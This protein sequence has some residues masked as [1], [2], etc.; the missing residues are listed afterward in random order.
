MPYSVSIDEFAAMLRQQYP[1]MGDGLS[2]L[3][4]SQLYFQKYPDSKYLE[5]IENP[6]LLFA[7]AEDP[8]A[9]ATSDEPMG[10]KAANYAIARQNYATEG[11]KA[12]PGFGK[13]LA[14]RMAEHITSI[15][16]AVAGYGGYIASA[17]GAEETGQEMID[18]GE[19]GAFGREWGRDFMEEWVEDDLELQALQLWQEDEPVTFYEDGKIGNFVQ[20]DMFVRGMASAMPS[21]IEMGLT[22]AATRGA[23]ALFYVGKAGKASL[24]L[25]RAWKKAHKA[26]TIGGIAAGTTLEGSETWNTAMAYGKEQG[27][28][29]KEAAKIAGVAT[30]IAAPIKGAME[31]LGF[32]KMARAIGLKEVGEREM[33]RILTGKVIKNMVG[34]GTAKGL[35]VGSTEAMTEW[36]QFMTDAIVQKGYKDGLGETPAEILNALIQVG[37]DEGWSAEARESIYGGFLMGGTTGGTGGATKAFGR[38]TPEKLTKRLKEIDAWYE[39]VEEKLGVEN[40]P[41]AV[42]ELAKIKKLQLFDEVM[43]KAAEGMTDEQAKEFFKEVD[44]HY[45]GEDFEGDVESKPIVTKYKDIDEEDYSDYL[46]S[47]ALPD[48]REKMQKRLSEWNLDAATDEQ[49]E[50]DVYKYTKA[51]V[52]AKDLPVKYAILKFLAEDP[53]AFKVMQNQPENI[54]KRLVAIA[55]KGIIDSGGLGVDFDF[56]KATPQQLENLVKMFI[57]KGSFEMSSEGVSL[58]ESTAVTTNWDLE[59]MNDTEIKSLFVHQDRD[60]AYGAIEDIFG[61]E[62]ADKLIDDITDIAPD[63]LTTIETEAEVSNEAIEAAILGKGVQVDEEQAKRILAHDKAEHPE[64]FEEEETPAPVVEEKDTLKEYRDEIGKPEQTEE[65]S[66][67]Y[68]LDIYKEEMASGENTE[69]EVIEFG[70]KAYK[71]HKAEL[72]KFDKDPVAYLENELYG[73]EGWVKYVEEQK[74]KDPSFDAGTNIDTLEKLL[75][76]AKEQEGVDTKPT[77]V[78]GKTGKER[79]KGDV[80]A[81]KYNKKRNEIT[82]DKDALK[83]KFD[84]KA[85]TKP[86]VKGVIALPENAFETYEAFEQFVVEHEVLHSKWKQGDGE[87]AGSYENRINKMAMKNLGLWEEGV[88]ETSQKEEDV[89][90]PES[91][92]LSQAINYTLGERGK[93]SKEETSY[94]NFVEEAGKERDRLVKKYKEEWDTIVK[95]KND[96][97][98]ADARIVEKYYDELSDDAK[99]YFDKLAP[100]VEQEYEMEGSPYYFGRHPDDGLI[101]GSN[102]YGLDLDLE[103][104]PRVVEP[105]TTLQERMTEQIEKEINPSAKKHLKK[106]QVK[107]KIATQFIGKGAEGSSTYNY[108]RM[109]QKEGVANTTKYTKDDIIYVSSNGKR[110]GRVNPVKDGVLQGVYKNID[111]A[112][113]VGAKIVMDTAAHLEATSGYNIGE[114]ALANYMRDNGYQRV[115]ETGV[116]EK[117]WEGTIIRPPSTPEADNNITSDSQDPLLAALTNRTALARKK[118]NLDKQYPV[119]FS[120]TGK[121]YRESKRFRSAE[122]A[123]Q[124]YRSDRKNPDIA[125]D[126]ALMVDIIQAKLEQ[127]PELAEQITER[128]GTD[129]LQTMRHDIGQSRWTGKGEDSLFIRALMDAYERVIAPPSVAPTTQ[130]SPLG[131][132]HIPKSK[133]ND[134]TTYEKVV[135][136]IIRETEGATTRKGHKAVWFGEKPYSYTGA[137]HTA[138][139]MPDEIIEIMHKVEDALGF[140]RGYYNSVL[141]NEYPAGVGIDAHAD[142]EEILVLDETGHVGHVGVLSLGGDSVIRIHEVGK[143]TYPVGMSGL[144]EELTIK[145]GDIYNLPAGDFQNAYLHSVGKSKAPRIS[146]TFRKI[147]EPAAPASEDASGTGTGSILDIMEEIEQEERDKEN[148]T[149][150]SRHPKRPKKPANTVQEA[151]DE[152]T[153]AV[154]VTRDPDNR[155]ITLKGGKVIQYNDDQQ[156]GFDKIMAWIGR[157]EQYEDKSHFA[158]MGY[159]GTGKSTLVS[160]IIGELRELGVSRDKIGLAAPTHAAAKLL[161]RLGDKAAITVASLMAMQKDIN[162]AAY[163]SGKAGFISDGDVSLAMKS[164]RGGYIIIDESSM[165]NREQLEDMLK[166]FDYYNINAIY[167]GDPAQLPPVGE[168]SSAAFKIGDRFPDLVDQFESHELTM[169]ERQAEDNPIFDIFNRLRYAIRNLVS[170][171]SIPYKKVFNKPRES[172]SSWARNT[173]EA[174]QG[175]YFTK[176]PLKWI[177]AAVDMFKSDAFKRDKFN[178]RIITGTKEFKRRWNNHVRGNGQT[179]VRGVVSQQERGGLWD[180][181]DEQFVEGETMIPNENR[182]AR[183]KQGD[184]NPNTRDS[185]GVGGEMSSDETIFNAVPFEILS[186]EE[187]QRDYEI[188]LPDLKAG[189]ISSIKIKEGDPRLKTQIDGYWVRIRDGIETVKEKQEDGTVIEVDKNINEREI[190]IVK[191]TNKRVRKFDNK[192]RK[193]IELGN[194]KTISVKDW[195]NPQY[196]NDDYLDSNDAWVKTANFIRLQQMN[197]TSGAEMSYWSSIMQEF[198]TRHLRQFYWQVGVSDYGEPKLL[199]PDVE[200]GYATTVHKAQG[201]TMVNAFVDEGSV[202]SYGFAQRTYSAVKAYVKKTYGRENVTAHD[203]RLANTIRDRMLYTAFTRPTDKL[204]VLNDRPYQDKHG[205]V[206]Q[207]ITEAMPPDFEYQTQGRTSVYSHWTRDVQNFEKIQERLAKHF[208]GVKLK[209]Y[210]TIVDKHGAAK[211]GRALGY[212]AEWSRSKATLDTIPHEYAHIYL[213]MYEDSAIVKKGIE[214]FG[215]EKLATYMGEYYAGRMTGSLKKK[216][217]LFLRQ[218]WLWIKKNVA[219]KTMTDQDVLDYMA[220]VFWSGKVLGKARVFTTD[221]EWEYMSEESESNW[222]DGRTALDYHSK[223]WFE[224][225]IKHRIS[226]MDY[227][228]LVELAAQ[229]DDFDAFHQEYINFFTN[230]PD[231]LYDNADLSNINLKH[232]RDF[233]QRKGSSIN[234][235]SDATGQ[236]KLELEVVFT[237]NGLEI[238]QK[239]MTYKLYSTTADQEGQMKEL[240]DLKNIPPYSNMTFTELDGVNTIFLNL[241]DIVQEHIS[242]KDQHKWWTAPSQVLF[243]QSSERPQGS[244]A[245]ILSM[246]EMEAAGYIYVASK[247]GDHAS[248]LF[249]KVPKR[250]ENMTREEFTAYWQKELDN[251]HITL[252]DF[253]TMYRHTNEIV[254]GGK[255]QEYSH[256]V[257]KHEWWKSVKYPQYL[258]GT[259]IGSSAEKKMGVQDHYDRLKINFQKGFTVRALGESSIMSIDSENAEV[260]IGNSPRKSLEEFDGWMLS[261]G[262]WFKKLG[263]ALGEEN[264]TAIKGAL[265]SRSG[266]GSNINY[267]GTKSMQM[268]P[269]PGMKIYEKGTDNL[270][271]IYRRQ[272]RAGSWETP[273]GVK[274][275][276]VS[277]TDT[278][279]MT[280]GIY[281]ELNTVQ[282]LPEGYQKVTKVPHYATSAAFPVTQ[283][284]IAMDREMLKDITAGNWS[285]AM[286]EYVDEIIK[287]YTDDMSLFIGERDADGSVS[288]PA[289]FK[290]LN[291]QVQDNDLM[292]EMQRYT[293]LIGRDGKGF[294]HPSLVPMWIDSIKNKFIKHGMM[295]LRNRKKGLGTILF[296]KPYFP[297]AFGDRELGERDF[298]ASSDNAAIRQQV[299]RAYKEAQPEKADELDG[300]KGRHGYPSHLYLKELNRWLDEKVDGKYVNHVPVLLSRQPIA[301][302][303]GV[304]T[305]NIRHLKEGGHGQTIFLSNHDV[306]KVFDGDWDGDTGMVAVITNKKILDSYVKFNKGK[307]FAKKKKA[308]NLI[309][310]GKRL[311]DTTLTNP[312]DVARTV[313]NINAGM[314]QIGMITNARNTLFSMNYKRMKLEFN[315]GTTMVT[316]NPQQKVLMDYVHLDIDTIMKTVDG[317]PAKLFQDI[318]LDG[319]AV[320]FVSEENIGG[321]KK[322]DFGAYNHE[323]KTVDDVAK[324]QEYVLKG[325]KGGFHLQTTK[326]HELSN[327]LQM[328]VDDSK[329]GLL[330]GLKGRLDNNNQF[331]VGLMFTQQGKQGKDKVMSGYYN[332][333]K[334]QKYYDTLRQVKKSFNFSPMRQGQD[335]TGVQPI[336]FDLKGFFENSKNVN[337]YGEPQ[338]PARLQKI[339]VSQNREKTARQAQNRTVFG[340]NALKLQQQLWREAQGVQLKDEGG[341]YY[342]FKQETPQDRIIKSLGTFYKKV[343]NPSVHGNLGEVPFYYTNESSLKAHRKSIMLLNRNWEEKFNKEKGVEW[344]PSETDL[345]RA[346]QF[347]EATAAEYY[348]MVGEADKK[349]SLDFSDDVDAFKDKW[350][351]V[352]EAMTPDQQALS[353]IYQLIGTSSDLGGNFAR[354]YNKMKK[355][356]PIDMMHEGVLKMYLTQWHDN[357]MSDRL[358][359]GV[360]KRPQDF[361]KKANIGY[362]FNRVSNKERTELEK[363]CG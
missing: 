224:S 232:L 206:E 7:T 43:G 8:I 152:Q 137:D 67:A 97:N 187:G 30:S 119:R 254:Q 213:N 45:L 337:K 29:N 195:D 92:E 102:L 286:N 207:P 236:G 212:L 329:F 274:F 291:K 82:I 328:A 251:G 109:Y 60:I 220:G 51:V 71:R 166:L 12:A 62:R 134:L 95:S 107:T 178:T 124:E 182:K 308:V 272:G 256:N 93:G 330:G 47:L 287:S 311:Q 327:I 173:N 234:I 269:F 14:Y 35:T 208:P 298:A 171:E 294:M 75:A 262:T 52:D 191:N 231:G 42:K 313:N 9:E 57:A 118:G 350:M 4:L 259:H 238:K 351:P 145:D 139:T 332:I 64:L 260:T 211:L 32:T 81:A 17:M 271:A 27:M 19:D 169:V 338:F 299:E 293:E 77:I 245:A 144:V 167:M 112:I 196:T 326:E 282:K 28:S 219:P 37:V 319:D 343:V 301:K 73:D 111:K 181:P 69:A 94:Y 10:T 16:G 362:D 121:R 170:G 189:E 130:V 348:P 63:E 257:A 223:S 296:Y 277:P 31:Y 1:E 84:E 126:F 18:W 226:R 316:Y 54:R 41:D 216:V 358:N 233:W 53:A 159:A 122:K 202:D 217:G 227:G 360:P 55:T 13:Q 255:T 176:E 65:E 205:A 105:T 352:W 20:G 150:P 247:G 162:L 66:I 309:Y 87:T 334:V 199:D 114:V 125:H 106:E 177:L 158:L 115:G 248:L 72:E 314:N 175:L 241:N 24:T 363:L 138:K 78:Y 307:E 141:M 58:G 179:H 33:V 354:K 303:T 89:S 96:P 103:Q 147:K 165:I 317:V 264:L 280:N 323:L 290:H 198:E 131:V 23:A 279:K 209:S 128:G 149:P 136:K 154:E 186:Y 356:L 237:G 22:S 210:Q 133:E 243:Q 183:Y 91:Q 46:Q 88:G 346:V 39:E 123:Y 129:W 193:Q 3:E 5:N 359:E 361:G 44:D 267:I 140:E 249:T 172:N 265:R 335:K 215:K 143:T 26:G 214:K 284:E 161:G 48:R 197:A 305:R 242:S 228:K 21:L 342:D 50:T 268:R 117:V 174:G 235:Y 74:L 230:H 306:L 100:G 336:E 76:K 70:K 253:K 108:M 192:A 61:K 153:G 160:D 85:W 244:S 222:T 11:S 127:H 318:Q 188:Q 6:D 310:F 297:P 135:K 156:S 273:D 164:L 36:M 331:L 146:L 200:Y 59:N 353:T 221:G 90:A 38:S 246:N 325:G 56:K 333:L 344:T 157:T 266:E 239:G 263:D 155:K 185:V 101:H 250:F 80:V 339:Y 218:F 25:A 322:N 204:L 229:Q 270:I 225:N 168:M 86:K 110:K 49:K 357:L 104:S 83:Q 341:I 278:S 302:L 151:M 142:A 345:K 98:R 190:F 292:T 163:T 113:E 201:S 194:G 68:Y 120:Y 288:A 340:G 324:A 283:G 116:W 40:A 289:L 281:S 240:V 79:S 180:N 312:H 15:P 275:D 285:E 203:Q 304:V 320:Y 276:H 315:D 34:R 300:M 349:I 321:G 148:I 258:R 355:F 132:T 99:Q 184:A 347:A 295:K 261:S 252:E 2:D